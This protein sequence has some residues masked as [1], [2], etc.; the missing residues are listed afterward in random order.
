[1]RHDFKNTHNFAVNFQ[2]NKN[3]KIF[4]FL[5][6]KKIYII[7]IHSIMVPSTVRINK[8]GATAPELF[9]EK[10]DQDR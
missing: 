5:S 10:P 6:E 7:P 8:Q 3:L 4:N 2:K 1:V 9:E